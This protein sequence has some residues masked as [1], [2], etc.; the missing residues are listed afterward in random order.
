MAHNDAGGPGYTL[1]ELAV[2]SGATL[3]GDGAV[4][5]TRVAT[6]ERA[7]P[8][9]IAFLANPKYASQLVSTR[10]SAVIVGPGDAA[11][12]PLPKLVT[13]TPYLAYARVATLLHPPATPMSGV[14]PTAVVDPGATIATGVAVGPH[15]TVAAGAVIGEGAVIGAGAAIGRDVR[16]GARTRIDARV[17]I[18]DGCAIGVDVIVYSGAV[19]GAD[20]FGMAPDGGRWVKIP[21]V[22]AV[23]VGDDVE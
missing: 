3:D 8:G 2:K 9:A 13:P 17:V 19:I 10:A 7:S 11:R 18:Y 4:R 23:R 6:L 12:T 16:I 21:Q 22:G 5:V 1:A 14:H 20:G 15:A